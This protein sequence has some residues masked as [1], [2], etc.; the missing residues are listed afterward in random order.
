M[1]LKLYVLW[2]TDE[3]RYCQCKHCLVVATSE[4]QA[5]WIDPS[6]GFLTEEIVKKLTEPYLGNENDLVLDTDEGYWIHPTKL[7]V[8]YLGDLRSD[9]YKAGDVICTCWQEA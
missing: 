2:N 7:K 9:K 1:T 5:K 8:E 4:E 3:Y 6:G